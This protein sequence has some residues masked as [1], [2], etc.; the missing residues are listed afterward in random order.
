M[1]TITTKEQKFYTVSQFS[2]VL[3]EQGIFIGGQGIRDYI[4]AGRISARRDIFRPK[5]WMIPHT[6]LNRLTNQ[7]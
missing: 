3:S 1:A 5:L 2:K 6:E 4:K 7:E